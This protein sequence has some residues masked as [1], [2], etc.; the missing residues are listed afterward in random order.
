[1]D[2]H[3][4]TVRGGWWTRWWRFA[5]IE[6]LQALRLSRSPLDR[7]CGTATL[8]LDTAGASGDGPRL[9]LR[10]VPFEQAR[11]LHDQ[12]SQ[13]LTRRRLRW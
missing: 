5:E 11:A 9:K 7:R 13:T 12:L 6:K 3:L 2:E 8:L 1:V 10:F 4:V